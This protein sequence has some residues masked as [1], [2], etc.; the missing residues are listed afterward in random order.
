MGTPFEV[1]ISLVVVLMGGFAVFGFLEIK[2]QISGIDSEI[3]M[4]YDSHRDTRDDFDRLRQKPVE[5]LLHTDHVVCSGCQAT[6]ARFFRD[7]DG[8]SVCA[9]CDPEGFVASGKV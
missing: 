3:E 7:T 2:K 5:C 1:I 9:N 4:L 6:V 8:N